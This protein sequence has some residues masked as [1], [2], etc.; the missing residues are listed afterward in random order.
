M[1]EQRIEENGSEDG[2]Q[3]EVPDGLNELLYEFAVSV[4]IDKPDNLHEFAADYFNKLKEEKK[5][6]SIPMYIIVDD[7][8][9]AGEPLEIRKLTEK[10]RA[11]RRKSVSAEK[12]NP[13]EDDSDEESLPIHPKTDEQREH[14]K[15]AVQNILLFRTLDREQRMT[16]INAMTEKHVNSGEVVIQQGDDGDFFYVIGN[17]I[18]DV[19]T[20][21]ENKQDKKVHTFNGKGSFGEL[22]LMYSQPRS[23]T[24]IASTQGLLWALD[25][26]SFQR[27]VQKESYKNRQM[28]EQLLSEVPFLN[29]LSEEERSSVV[30]GLCTKEFNDNDV[31]IRRG[32]EGD[33]IFFIEH[34]VCS[35][36]LDKGAGE[37][38]VKRLSN[39]KYFGE[40]ALLD[41]SKRTASIYA[42]GD[43][44]CGFLSRDSFERLLGPCRDIMK[45]ATANF[46]FSK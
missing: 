19:Y 5:T 6:K 2:K 22:A 34:G 9:E 15:Q 18:Y 12:Y 3:Y 28:Y 35:V 42:I 37:V 31:I 26:K 25:R 4:L 16:V 39:G 13:E 23:A 36:R 30:D 40:L 27:I 43:V 44:K 1:S 45:R 20:H 38:E 7:D 29:A 14:L 17:G 8:D 24:V 11:A 10:N 32:D 41:N 21:D 46:E 33:G